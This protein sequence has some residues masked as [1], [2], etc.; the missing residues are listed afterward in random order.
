M[1]GAKQQG[2][3]SEGSVSGS[4]EKEFERLMQPVGSKKQQQERAERGGGRN[5]E[6][7]ADRRDVQA[8]AL[9]AAVAEEEAN[10]RL[11][12]ASLNLISMHRQV[13]AGM[14][15]MVKKEM[16][17]VNTTDADRD[18]IEEYLEGLE[19]L[20]EKKSEM[21]SGVRDA[22]SSWKD[23]RVGAERERDIRKKMDAAKMSEQ[24]V[25]A[26]RMSASKWLGSMDDD[27]GGGD[28]GGGGDDD[29]DD[30]R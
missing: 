23:A 10:S 13:I 1:A 28:G 4:M 12:V 17:M 8:A 16:Q 25:A 22:L 19:A 9:A 20:Q 2:G 6:A 27:G 15:G 26:R 21:V 3:G 14:L 18:G 11:K 5:E 24:R 29:D 30:L 7:K